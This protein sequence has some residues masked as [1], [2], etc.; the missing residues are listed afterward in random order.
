MT[1]NKLIEACAAYHE[2]LVTVTQ[3]YHWLVAHEFSPVTLY[4]GMWPYL[5]N[6]CGGA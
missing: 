3:F 4:A 6:L 1:T 5:N 2:H